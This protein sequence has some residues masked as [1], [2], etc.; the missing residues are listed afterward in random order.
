MHCVILV[1]HH[2]KTQFGGLKLIRPVVGVQALTSLI[3]YIY[4]WN[5]QFLNNVNINKTIVI[6]LLVHMTLV[7]FDSTALGL[8]VYF[9]N[10]LFG[11][12]IFVL[13]TYI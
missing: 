13:S 7:Y 11:F 3:I 8:L 12:P 5:L 6:L 4:Y 2:Y 1:G 10:T 9:S